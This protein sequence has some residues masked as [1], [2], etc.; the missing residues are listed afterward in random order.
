MMHPLAQPQPSGQDHG[1][2]LGLVI[3]RLVLH[4]DRVPVPVLWFRPSV[5]WRDR[6]LLERESHRASSLF[7]LIVVSWMDR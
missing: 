1:S 5:D 7:G 3:R 6:A 2:H 4:R